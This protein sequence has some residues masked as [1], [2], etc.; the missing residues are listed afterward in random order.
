HG[1]QVEVTQFPDSRSADSLRISVG[2]EPGVYD[3]RLTKPGYA[4][5]T[6]T[7]ARVEDSGTCRWPVT[8]NLEARLARVP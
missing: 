7:W 6:R 8:V 5:W 3:L 1:G 4:D 2:L